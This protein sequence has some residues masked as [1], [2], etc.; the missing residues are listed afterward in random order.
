MVEII[1]VVVFVV[2]AA[3]VDSAAA[4]YFY[5]VFVVVVV[6]TVDECSNRAQVS[7]SF[8]LVSPRQII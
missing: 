1:P 5:V 4:V 7:S 2:V 6:I 8:S 3:L